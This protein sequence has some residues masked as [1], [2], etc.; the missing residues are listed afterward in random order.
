MNEMKAAGHG[1][2]EEDNLKQLLALRQY[3]RKS[4]KASHELNGLEGLY[5]QESK[6]GLADLKVTSSPMP[7]PNI[8]KLGSGYDILYANPQAIGTID[9]GFR[10]SV[11]NMSISSGKLTPDQRFAIPDGTQV[12]MCQTCVVSFSSTE[13]QG[14]ASYVDTLK[15]AVK[16]SLSGWGAAFKASF[17]YQ[18]VDRGSSNYSEKFTKSTAVCEV[19]CSQILTF[20]PPPLSENFLSGV[21]QVL[22]LPYNNDSL[23]NYRRFLG[24]FGTHVITAARM[25]GSFG[26]QST[27]SSSAW[28]RYHMSGFDVSAEAS[29]SAFSVSGAASAMSSQQREQA[30]K[31]LVEVLLEILQNSSKF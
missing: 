21:D 7:M 30:C 25:G 23:P 18:S 9:P 14:G 8:D 29:A 31:T 26:E 4:K 5:K 1:R 27:F 20:T 19:Y 6:R 17:D 13:V 10:D 11:Y 22:T 12:S 3:T 2:L 16:G 24:A 15:T 28:A